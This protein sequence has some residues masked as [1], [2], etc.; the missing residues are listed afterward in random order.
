MTVLAFMLTVAP[1]AGP[2]VLIATESPEFGSMALLA[3]VCAG[4]S[5]VLRHT[6]PEAARDHRSRHHE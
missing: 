2:P 3:A 4:L 5:V 6:T 1:A